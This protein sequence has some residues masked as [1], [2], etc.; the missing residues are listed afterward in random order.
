MFLETGV[1]LPAC[2]SAGP[3]SAN[4][5]TCAAM[6]FS[7]MVV[8]TSWA[9]VRAFRKPGMKPQKPPASVAPAMANTRITRLGSP[10]VWSETPTNV[11]PSAPMISWPSPPMLNMPVRNEI[12][13][14]RP[15][16]MR[17]VAATRVSVIGRMA[18]AMVRGPGF[19]NARA[20]R[21]RVAEGAR[22][23]G[24]VAVEHAPDRAADRAHGIAPDPRQV[25]D[26]G[27]DDHD[28]AEDQRGQDGQG[29]DQGSAED[30]RDLLH[31]A[32]PSPNVAPPISRP[33]FS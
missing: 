7:M 29:R 32:V 25:L 5:T 28:A 2:R 17:G 6:M 14:A 3:S 27:D 21:L 26:V 9:P 15:T 30:A 20:I 23:H 31:A 4:S 16:K 13:T 22:Q 18:V 8:M 33:R 11:A 12:A 24:P 19:S 1:E 10:E